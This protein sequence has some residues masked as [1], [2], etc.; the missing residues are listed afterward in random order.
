MRFGLSSS[1]DD[2]R[3]T[4]DGPVRREAARG[5]RGVPVSG[6]EVALQGAAERPAV[7]AERRGL[8]PAETAACERHARRLPFASAP[9]GGERSDPLGALLLGVGG[10]P[11]RRPRSWR[12]RGAAGPTGAFR[13]PWSREPAKLYS[14]RD[15]GGAGQAQGPLAR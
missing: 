14:Q 3:K 8:A 11:G 9:K 15:P 7:R 10:G 13:A 6:S 12:G 2:A 1:L 5:C 4:L